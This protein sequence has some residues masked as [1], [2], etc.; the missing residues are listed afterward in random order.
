MRFVAAW[1]S[2]NFFIRQNVGKINYS[3]EAFSVD[4][5]DE[6]THANL[7]TYFGELIIIMCPLL[8]EFKYECAYVCVCVCVW[9]MPKLMDNV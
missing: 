3:E 9:Q 2:F 5:E 1:S 6:N 7:K 4:Y 8:I